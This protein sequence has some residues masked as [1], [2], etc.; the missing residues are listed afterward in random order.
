MHLMSILH[1]SLLSIA[2]AQCG[3]WRL[4]SRGSKYLEENVAAAAVMLTR[5]EM[6]ALDDAL[7]PE[8]ISGLR[9]NDRM[10]QVDR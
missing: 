2:G 6:A 4:I 7:A 3:C 5:D 1:C 10:K 8:R 9:Y